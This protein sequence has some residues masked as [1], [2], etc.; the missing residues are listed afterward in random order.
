MVVEAFCSFEVVRVVAVDVVTVVVEITAHRHKHHLLTYLQCLMAVDIYNHSKVS[1]QSI[2]LVAGCIGS[3]GRYS[4]S[5]VFAALPSSS[6]SSSS[7]ELANCTLSLQ[8]TCCQ[9][10]QPQPLWVMHGPNT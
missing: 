2:T 4:C 10:L 5:A 1:V 6:S 9:L 7:S 3:Q 8:V